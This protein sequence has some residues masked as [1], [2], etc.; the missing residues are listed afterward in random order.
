MLLFVS[1]SPMTCPPR[2][3]SLALQA[4]AHQCTIWFMNHVVQKEG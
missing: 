4:V 2:S 3:R 1:P